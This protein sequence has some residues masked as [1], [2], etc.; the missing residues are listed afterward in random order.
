MIE[1]CI[2]NDASFLYE[3]L[4]YLN[5]YMNLLITHRARGQQPENLN[6]KAKQK[7]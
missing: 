4:I 5:E 3:L 7:R 2:F 6:V 1:M